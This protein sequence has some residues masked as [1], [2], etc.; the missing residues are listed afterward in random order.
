MSKTV[1][2]IVF[3]S[4]TGVEGISEAVC[5]AAIPDPFIKG[6]VCAAIPLV[7]NCIIA[8]CKLFVKDGGTK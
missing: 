2:N 7:C 3:A 6:A 5:A 8:V 4:V 1:Y